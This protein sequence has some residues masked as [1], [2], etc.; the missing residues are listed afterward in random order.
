[1]TSILAASQPQSRSHTAKLSPTSSN[2]IPMNRLVW[3][4]FQGMWWPAFYYSDVF[5]FNGL[6]T[7]ELD[8]KNDQKTKA[9]L[10]F[11]MLNQHLAEG[12]TD[13]NTKV[14]RFL[15]RPVCDFQYVDDRLDD[16]YKDFFAFL[17]QMMLTSCRPENFNCHREI[18]LDFHPLI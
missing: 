8:E 17:P 12:Q 1:M 16:Q 7:G 5:E 3:A 15:G 2:F 18:Y 10:A 13:P 6:V 14:I 9:R 4:K 11:Q